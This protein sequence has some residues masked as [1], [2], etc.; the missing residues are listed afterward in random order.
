MKK[1][2]TLIA[3][4]SALVPAIHGMDTNLPADVQKKYDNL[5]ALIQNADIES[6]KPAFDG[7]TLPT[8]S[9]A[10]LRN[11]VAETKTTVTKELEAI[12]DKT[13]SWSKIVKGGL[14]TFLSGWAGLAA[15]ATGAMILFDPASMNNAL[16]MF[17]VAA[18]LPVG[19]PCMIIMHGIEKIKNSATS[20][21]TNRSIGAIIALACLGAA[22]KGIPY[23]LKTFKAGWNYKEHLQN[24]LTNLDAIDAHIAQ[25]KA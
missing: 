19:I 8:E 10:A 13:K 7:T 12:G 15:P 16:I 25:A 20:I 21:T 2:F 24:M 4:S 9:I 1:F 23:G 5:T 18:V 22:Y 11:T 17:L 3:L 14:T 6:F